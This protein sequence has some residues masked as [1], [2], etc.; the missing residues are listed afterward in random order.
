[1]AGLGSRCE[2]QYIRI[3]HRHLMPNNAFER[4]VSHR[5]PRLSAAQRWCSAAQRGR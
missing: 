3:E 1:M 2:L 4:T 5:G